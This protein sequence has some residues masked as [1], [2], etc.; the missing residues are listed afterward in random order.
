LAT[1]FRDSYSKNLMGRETLSWA[2]M[3]L[4]ISLLLLLLLPSTASAAELT[5]KFD[6]SPGVRLGSTH[7]VEGTLTQ[8][9]APLAGQAVEI[10]ARRY[11]YRGGFEPLRTVTTGEDG[12]F[13]LELEFRRNTQLRASAPAQGLVT[14]FI[15]AYV[16]P[17]PKSTFKALDDGRLRIK[18]ILRTPPGTK[19][20]APSIFYLGPRKAKT[21]ERFASAKPKRIG[22]GK[23][24]ATATVVIPDSW[25]GFFRYASCFR[26]S[27]GSGLGD[28]K[29]H[30]P[31]R[32][33]F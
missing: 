31:T 12:S 19:L 29:A 24:R 18:Q 4:V 13:R 14:R 7:T 9:G 28:P 2:A 26:Y 6:G 1:I 17:R 32:Y 22:K 25:N 5:F 10:D 23:Y 3:R 21:A 33:R 20:T 16:F 8:D 11:P 15:S 30:C 27:T